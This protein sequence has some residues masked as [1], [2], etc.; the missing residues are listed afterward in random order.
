MS[1]QAALHDPLFRFYAALILG[2]LA[3]AGLALTAITYGARK[4]IPS[5]WATYRGWLV[6]IPI[7]GGALFL[8]RTATIV[9]FS[10]VALLGFKEFASATGLYRDWGLTGIVYLAIL[11]QAYL[12]W[13]TDPFT[14]QLGWF[15]MFR[16]LPVYAIAAIL[17]V[18]IVRNRTHRQLQA[19]SLTVVGFLYMVWM[20]GHLLFLANSDR[21]YAYLFYLLLAVELNDIAAFTFGRLFGRHK[22]R[23]EISP[24]KTWE[25]S[26][27]A[28]AVSMALPWLIPFALPHFGPRERILTGLIVGV[29]GQLGDLSISVIK[30]DVGV[31]DMGA[32]LPGHGG[33]LDRIDSLIYT[34]PL[35]LH[36]VNWFYG[37]YG[38]R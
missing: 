10:V 31:K 11:A 12:A 35:F 8:G 23:S 34:A 22:L 32:T 30:R 18:P 26:L 36:M 15:G 27:G 7:V 4:P 29:G 19:V 5:V 33:I 13:I 16:T 9:T 1:I 17:M 20:F 25:G 2:L 38:V 21:P 14:G 6:I 37:L 24:N 3:A 28:L